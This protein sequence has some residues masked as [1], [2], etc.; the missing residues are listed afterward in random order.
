[1][2]YLPSPL[3]IF[4]RL[5]DPSPNIL[6]VIECNVDEG[7]VLITDKIEVLYSAILHE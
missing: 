1:M 5:I 2:E 4:Q 3:F 6:P 7:I